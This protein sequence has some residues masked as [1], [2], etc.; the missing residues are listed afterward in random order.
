MN[1][2]NPRQSEAVRHFKGPMIVLA[3]PGSGK[4]TIIT[5][6]V[7]FLLENYNVQDKNILVITFTK[8]AA[9]EMKQR[10]KK[11]HGENKVLFATF[12]SFFFRI[13]RKFY[14]YSL[15]NILKEGERKNILKQIIISNFNFEIDDD[16][17]SSILNEISLLK[18]ELLDINFYNSNSCGSDDFRKIYHAY[19]KYK[20]D[21]KK[22]DFDDMLVLCYKILS[23]NK[24][25]LELYRRVYKF[26]LIDEFQDINRAQYECIKLLTNKNLF[27]V[28]DDDQSIYKFRGACPE[29]LLNFPKDFTDTKIIVLDKNYRSSEKIISFCSKII[30]QN[31]NRYE[32]K[33]SGTGIIGTTPKILEFNNITDEAKK[34]SEMIKNTSD[35]INDTAVIFRTNIQAQ[36]FMTNFMNLNIPYKLKD[37]FPSLYEHW[38]IKDILAYMKFSL[39]NSDIA[40]LYKIINRPKRF[41]SKTM[42]VK[43]AKKSYN[44]LE[45]LFNDK[46]LPIWRRTPIEELLFN[47][48]QMKLKN[49]YDSVRYIRKIIG[50][51]KFIREFSDNQNI[52]SKWLFEIMD[53]FQES[54]KNFPDTQDFVSYA[55][56][57]SINTKKNSD[58]VTLTTMHSVKGLEFD[59]VFLI[60]AV[61]GLIPHEKSKTDYEIAEELRLFYVALT[62]A[63][64]NLFISITKNR[65]ELPAKPTRFLSA[66][67][68]I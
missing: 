2:L 26:I 49:S 21:K 14:N 61:E 54:A 66:T 18:N 41:I 1:N 7:K 25:I 34:I 60:S 9:D 46:V 43:A 37:E 17:L 8:A 56:N 67:I 13:I 45:N 50:Y 47:L 38:A 65:Y 35:K 30:E 62:R 3:G 12:H 42:L 52:K 28:G 20:K 32:K 24:N 33:I 48:N 11:I 23:S 36:S 57:F 15:E 58:G 31:K 55:E 4:T 39:D 5:R 16:F 40:S 44:I 64:N 68:K 22:I 53:E 6:R 29:F 27:A 63:K 51:D 19:E 59:T 10:F